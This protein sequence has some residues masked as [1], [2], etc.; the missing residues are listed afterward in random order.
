VCLIGDHI[1]EIA[2][3]NELLFSRGINFDKLPAWQKRGI[4]IYWTE[5]EK[6]GFNPL[7]RQ[8]VKTLRRTLQVSYEL[9]LGQQ[10]ADMVVAFL[11]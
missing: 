10:Y 4:G 11:A 2:W 7:T 8:E 3:K 9:P 1:E 6:A 5:V